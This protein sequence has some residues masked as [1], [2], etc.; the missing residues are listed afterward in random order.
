[1]SGRRIGRRREVS[2]LE[3]TAVPRLGADATP[4]EAAQAVG[5]LADM[6]NESLPAP[7]YSADVTFAT[8]AN[9]IAHGLGRAPTMVQVAPKTAD[10]AFA[11]GWDPAQ[12][13][14]PRPDVLVTVTVAGGPMVARIEVR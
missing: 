5:E 11:W 12:P 6:L 10:A 2:P 4:S 8:G 9:T 1:M 7:A 3:R 14:N 13:G